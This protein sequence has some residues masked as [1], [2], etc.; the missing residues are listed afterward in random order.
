VKYSISGHVHYRKQ[1]RIQNTD[2]L[3]NCLG[4]RSEWVDNDDA[5]VEVHRAMKVIN[6]T[7]PYKKINA[8]RKNS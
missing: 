7:S 4:Y 8:Y 3:C 2:F 5:A 6:P 1:I